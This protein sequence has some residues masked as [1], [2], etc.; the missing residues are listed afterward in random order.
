MGFYRHIDTPWQV[1][2]LGAI[3]SLW[4]GHTGLLIVAYGNLET[5]LHEAIRPS[6]QDAFFALN[7]VSAL[8]WVV[9]S[10]LALTAVVAARSRRS[11]VLAV[12]LIGP[13]IGLAISVPSQQWEDPNWAVFVGICLI[14]WLASTTVCSVYLFMKRIERG[15]GMAYGFGH[16]ENSGPVPPAPTDKGSR[17]F[18]QGA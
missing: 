10:S 3:F 1:I 7:R 11:D 17:T 4:L 5:Y 18:V 12:L 16:D 9:H 6:R 15:M 14:G 13:A 8:F 2:A